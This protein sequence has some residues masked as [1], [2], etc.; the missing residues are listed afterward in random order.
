MAF[1]AF[2]YFP[3]DSKMV[4]ETQDKS[5]KENKATEILSFE[6][7]AENNI[8]IGSITAGGGAGKA[9]FKELTITKKTDLMSDM[10]F[11]SC[12]TGA[13]FDTMII[14]LRRS[15]QGGGGKAGT[16]LMWEFKLVMIQDI[17]WSGS[18][19]DDICE[20]T[21]VIQYGAMKV[22]YT[23]QKADGTAGTPTNKMWSR[24]LNEASLDV[25]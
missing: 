4:G 12:V 25:K 16:F 3:N 21:V 24:V 9:T 22:T 13:H 11:E 6:I 10:M 20:E 7:G 8:N 23:P 17:S 15:A 14:E 5:M 1:D 19:G 18:D 2:L